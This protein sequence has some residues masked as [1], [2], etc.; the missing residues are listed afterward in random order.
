M[1]TMPEVVTHKYDPERAFLAKLCDLLQAE[2]EKVLQRIRDAGR[3]A[4]KANYLARRVETEAWLA[5]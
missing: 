3:R 4:V 5:P 2:A 1:K